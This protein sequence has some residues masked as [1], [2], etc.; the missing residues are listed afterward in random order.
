MLELKCEK[1]PSNA[2]TSC[3]ARNA[4]F[5]EVQY[6]LLQGL[7]NE[8]GQCCTKSRQR[9]NAFSVRMPVLEC[10]STLSSSVWVRRPNFLGKGIDVAKEY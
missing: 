5:P 4:V 3:Q 10:S 9:K 8:Q 1:G 6:L 7:C 2:K